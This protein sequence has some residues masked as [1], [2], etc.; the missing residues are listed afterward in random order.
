MS[1]TKQEEDIR[2]ELAAAMHVVSEMAK[3]IDTN[4]QQDELYYEART[5]FSVY[6]QLRPLTP[7]KDTPQ[8]TKIVNFPCKREYPCSSTS[9]RVA[10]PRN[11]ATGIRV[12]C[13][14]LRDAARLWRVWL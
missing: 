13:V 12:V 1:I 11:G 4:M 7:E 10:A 6:Q 3:A 9:H 8:P 14:L 2:H 5:W